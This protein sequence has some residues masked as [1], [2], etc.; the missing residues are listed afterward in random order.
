MALEMIVFM[1]WV[2]QLITGWPHIL[3]F[4]GFIRRNRCPGL[5]FLRSSQVLGSCHVTGP[6][7]R[8]GR[9][10]WILQGVPPSGLYH[11]FLVSLKLFKG[12]FQDASG[13][14][15]FNGKKKRWFPVDFPWNQ[16]NDG[17]LGDGL[18]PHYRKPWNR[19]ILLGK[20]N[21]WK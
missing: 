4:T 10:L 11:L 7:W 14:P 17:D 18:L 21:W 1:G 6:I 3:D 19:W 20:T 15:I 9:D 13:R 12:N 5:R 16:S 8:L 2:S